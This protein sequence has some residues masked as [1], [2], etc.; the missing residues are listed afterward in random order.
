MSRKRLW[1][2][3]LSYSQTQTGAYALVLGEEGGPR[4]LPIIIGAFEAQSI[5]IALEKEINPPRPLTHDLF[6]QFSKAFKIEIKEVVIHSLKEGVFHA[7]MICLNEDGHEEVLDARTSDAVAL[8]TRFDCP[9]FTYEHILEKAGVVLE[10]SDEED[11]GASYSSENEDPI[12]E[13]MEQGAPEELSLEDLNAK[14]QEAVS[15]ED[16]EEAALLRDES[17]KRE[18][19]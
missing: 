17:S 12:E 7:S 4:T 15:N 16:Y 8:A 3:G 2:K 1:I 11:S 19:Q 13:L 14:L 9:I 5:A 10:E 18:K 6:A